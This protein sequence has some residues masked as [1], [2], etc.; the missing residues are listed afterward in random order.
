[1]LGEITS[2][3]KENM[4]LR[5]K[6]ADLEAKLADT[7][8]KTKKRSKSTKPS[9]MITPDHVGYSTA[10]LLVALRDVNGCNLAHD[11]LS[12]REVP[13]G[14]L[15]TEVDREKAVKMYCRLNNLVVDGSRF[16]ILDNLLYYLLVDDTKIMS[17]ISTI[18]SVNGNILFVIEV[19]K[20]NGY[21]KQIACALRR[22]DNL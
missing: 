17:S 11:L 18:T 7:D 6:I 8:N 2:L 10:T 19:G 1:M 13:G 5:A 22:L 20:G 3:V 21:I 12:L 4:E 16:V 9:W 15:I 14:M